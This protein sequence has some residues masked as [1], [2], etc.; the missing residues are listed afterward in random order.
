MHKRATA[1]AMFLAFG[2]LVGCTGTQVLPTKGDG[3]SQVSGAI[4][5]PDG[6]AGS[7]NEFCDHLELRATEA[8]GTEVGHARVDS[9][10]SYCEY[11]M[12]DLPT[13][14]PL[15]ISISSKS[16]IRCLRSESLVF[17]PDAVSMTLRDGD[18]REFNFQASC[19][20]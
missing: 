9:D 2:L 20:G 6:F 18:T 16:V 12:N 4:A 8:S 19:Q 15:E 14:T 7:P 13:F 11:R 17:H 1:F 3:H 5:V 10:T